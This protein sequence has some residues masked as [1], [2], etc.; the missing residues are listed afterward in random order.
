MKRLV[1]I[2]MCIGIILLL[3]GCEEDI[4]IEGTWMSCD[5]TLEQMLNNSDA[6]M[7]LMCTNSKDTSSGYVFTGHIYTFSEDHT[8]TYENIQTF[9]Y[10][11]KKGTYSI[12]NNNIELTY[13]SYEEDGEQQTLPN[14]ADFKFK[15]SG[16]KPKNADKKI[17]KLKIE[18]QGDIGD[19]RRLTDYEKWKKDMCSSYHFDVGKYQK[20]ACKNK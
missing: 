9:K 1:I 6:E 4:G 17:Y 5:H 13:N 12:Y 15:I 14:K 16:S 3:S 2:I 19:F 11:I 18:G 20:Y 7:E 8:F 10:S